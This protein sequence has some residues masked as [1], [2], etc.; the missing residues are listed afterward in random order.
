MSKKSILKSINKNIS[1]ARKKFKKDNDSIM[2][3][4]EDALRTEID[5]LYDTINTAIIS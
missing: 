4:P 2:F 3:S 1:I 5:Y